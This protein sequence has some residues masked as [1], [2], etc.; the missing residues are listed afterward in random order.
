MIVSVT[1]LI[2]VRTKNIYIKQLLVSYNVI[3][4]N[5][6]QNDTYVYLFPR[7]VFRTEE[8]VLPL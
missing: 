1:D 3:V 4:W 5:V 6:A 8:F 7:K 2:R